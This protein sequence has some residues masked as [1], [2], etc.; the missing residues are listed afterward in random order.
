MPMMVSLKDM[1]DD[2]GIEES[3]FENVV[4]LLVRSRTCSNTIGE[5]CCGLD[6]STWS[7]PISS[8]SATQK[9]TGHAHIHFV[10]VKEQDT[11]ISQLYSGRAHTS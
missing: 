2:C 10:S 9:Q 11:C 5:L 1:R 7:L 3:V 8:P 6:F 4:D